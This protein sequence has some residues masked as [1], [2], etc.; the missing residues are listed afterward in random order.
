MAAAVQQ[1]A[2]GS[3][4]TFAAAVDKATEAGVDAAIITAARADFAAS[5]DAA[6][7]ALHASAAAEGASAVSRALRVVQV[8]GVCKGH[9]LDVFVRRRRAAVEAVLG[10]MRS[11]D[12]E[13]LDAA[14]HGA[15]WLGMDAVQAAAQAAARLQAS[16]HAPA[17][18]LVTHGQPPRFQGLLKAWRA[19][20]ALPQSAQ[21]PSTPPCV[22]QQ[23]VPA[24]KDDALVPPT[25]LLRLLRRA[26]HGAAL[27]SVCVLNLTGQRCEC[28]PPLASLLPALQVL[29]VSGN[30]LTCLQGDVHW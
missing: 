1:A 13:A 2:Q 17:S 27:Q 19:W 30:H 12:R 21:Q 22:D 25:W 8:K 23:P 9:A 4:A 5:C 11:N 3:A 10:A 18:R 16:L 28:L 26:A 24:T 15:A 6:L 20:S 29:D 7:Q 14:V